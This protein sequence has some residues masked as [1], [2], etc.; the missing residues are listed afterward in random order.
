MLILSAQLVLSPRNW[1]SAS[2]VELINHRYN[3]K[4]QIKETLRGWCVRMCV[5]WEQLTLWKSSL[6]MKNKIKKL[7][8]CTIYI[9]GCANTMSLIIN[10]CKKKKI[11]YS[12]VLLTANLQAIQ[13]LELDDFLLLLC[14]SDF[15]FGTS[16]ISHVFKKLWN[17]KL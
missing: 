3:K 14:F 7:S 10:I 9:T 5:L 13:S 6:R 15:Y 12:M 8:T 2:G 16:T 11:I 17:V 1:L 4:Y